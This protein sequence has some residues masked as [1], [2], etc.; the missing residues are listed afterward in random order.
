MCRSN[1]LGDM[2]AK[3]YVVMEALGITQ[4]FS[5]RQA[6]PSYLQEWPEEINRRVPNLILNSNLGQCCTRIRATASQVCGVDH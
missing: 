2:V 3:I 6:W 4:Q 5:K 1:C